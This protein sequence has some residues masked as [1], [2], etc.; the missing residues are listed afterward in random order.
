MNSHIVIRIIA[1]VSLSALSCAASYSE[2]I[3]SALCRSSTLKAR[4][5]ERITQ[6]SVGL[7]ADI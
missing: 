4:L 7:E 2:R 3:A 6:F 5:G 1:S